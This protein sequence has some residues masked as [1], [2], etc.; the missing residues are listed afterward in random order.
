MLMSDAI[1]SDYVLNWGTD[2][3]RSDINDI[4]CQKCII[5]IMHWLRFIRPVLSLEEL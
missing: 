2:P 4:V 3:F 5:Q 1:H